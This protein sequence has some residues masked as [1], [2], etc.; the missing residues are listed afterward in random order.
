[1][2]SSCSVVEFKSQLELD[3]S[4]EHCDCGSSLSSGPEVIFF[5]LIQQNTL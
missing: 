3:L 2:L 1:M 5:Y 4:K